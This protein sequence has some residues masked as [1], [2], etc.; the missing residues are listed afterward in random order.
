MIRLFKI[1]ETDSEMRKRIID[2]AKP[3]DCGMLPPPMDAQVAMNELTKH[4]LGDDYYIVNPVNSEQGNTEIV[5]EIERRY[6]S[7]RK[8]KRFRLN[9]SWN[10][11]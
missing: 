1:K 2:L 10:N 11:K 8:P 6:K 7:K 9:I 4:L 5:Y 3:I